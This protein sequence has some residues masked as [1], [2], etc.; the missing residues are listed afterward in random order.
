[1]RACEL[2]IGQIPQSAPAVEPVTVADVVGSSTSFTRDSSSDEAGNLALWLPAA[3]RIVERDTER[4]LITATWRFTA[5][6]FPS[7]QW[8]LATKSPWQSIS[9]ITY[10]DSDGDSTVLASSDYRFVAATGI[11]EPAYN[12]SWPDTYD[13]AGAVTVDVVC[14]FG[15]TAATV[16]EEYR[17][18]IKAIVLDW[19]EGR[20]LRFTVSPGVREQLQSLHSGRY[21]G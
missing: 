17:L 6:G 5:D 2:T 12:E 20:A 14:G 15:L 13:V 21:W 18:L 4:Q 8:K 16:P 10:L 19:M 1:V 7:W 11:L 3:R 9:A